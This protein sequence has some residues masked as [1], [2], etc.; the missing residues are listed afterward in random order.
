MPKYAKFMKDLLTHRGRGNEA[1]KITLNERCSVVGLNEIPKKEK[2]LGSF[3]IPCVI[4]QRG[5]NKAL[6][7]LGASISLMPHSMFLRLN[8]GELK[9]TRMCIE[10]ADKSTQIPRGIAE[11]VIV[12]IDSLW[13]DNEGEQDL[14][15]LIS[16]N[17]KHESE[18]YIKPTLFAANLCKDEKPTTKLKD[19]PPYL[20]YAFLDNNLEFPIIISSPLSAQEKELLLRVLAKHKGPLAWKVIDIKGL[21]EVTNKSYNG[22]SCKLEVS[23]KVWE[24]LVVSQLRMNN[25]GRM[26]PLGGQDT[27]RRTMIMKGNEKNNET[28]I[29]PTPILSVEDLC[30]DV[31]MNIYFKVLGQ[32]TYLVASLTLDSARS[33]VML[34]ASFTQGTIPSIPIGG[35]ISPEGFLLPILLLVMIMVMVVIVAVILVVVV[36]AIVGVVI[37]VITI[38]VVFVVMII[39]VVVVIGVF[40]IIKLSTI[41]IGQEPF[42]FSPDDLVGLLYS[43]S[44]F[45]PMNETNNSFRTIEVKRLAAH[46]LLSSGGV[47]DLTDD[48]DPTDEDRDTGVGDSNFLVSLGEKTGVAKRY[49]VKSSEELGEVFPDVARK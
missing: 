40:A 17:L 44:L 27:Q 16:E 6:A 32:M 46:K 12:K 30:C 42:Q 41:L 35:S 7:D 38:G 5:I 13:D 36:V 1:S 9:P 43:N 24:V 2:D 11:N 22:E 15:N 4:G 48:E 26:W 20:E 19:L 10:L 37:V 23:M 33:Y 31:P 21:S 28:L 45:K 8:L 49:L 29:A 14:I 3:T 34:G 18:R 39:G 47:I 25:K